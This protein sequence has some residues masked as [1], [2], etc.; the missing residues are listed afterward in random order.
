MTNTTAAGPVWRYESEALPLSEA[1]QFHLILWKYGLS[2]VGFTSAGDP[3]MAATFLFESDWDIPRFRELL[4]DE[5]VFAGPQPIRT[6]WIAEERQ[7]LIPAPFFKDDFADVWLRTFH[8]IETEETLIHRP[9][10]PVLD[11]FAVFPLKE[12]LLELIREY[13]PEA[14]MRPLSLTTFSREG[15]ASAAARIRITNLP[16]LVLWSF[17]GNNQ[18]QHHQISPAEEPE[19]VLYTLGLYLQE[20]Q[21][22]QQSVAVELEGIAPFWKNLHLS[23]ADFFSAYRAEEDTTV[24]SLEFY[25]KLFT[26]AS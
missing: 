11:A 23:L 26:C 25:K 22:A 1:H 9:L 18:F 5:P 10:A 3:V 12:E 20:N 21:Q 7:L 13:L 14:K 24:T 17:I 15:G 8:F 16:K 19:N 4:I 2:Y 6:I